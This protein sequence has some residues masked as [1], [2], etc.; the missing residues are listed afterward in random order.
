MQIGVF[1]KIYVMRAYSRRRNSVA[2]SAI[3]L[4]LIALWPSWLSYA[5]TY[6]FIALVWANHHYLMRYA[7][8][9]TPRLLW[10]IF[11]HFFDV[12]ASRATFR[13]AH[14]L[15]V[16][17][18]KAGIQYSRDSGDRTG[19]PRRT[20][21]PLSRGMTACYRAP[22]TRSDHDPRRFTFRRPRFYSLFRLRLQLIKL[23]AEGNDK[24]QRFSA[25]SS[26]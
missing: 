4:P 18:A 2:Y 10:F 7:T 23:A 8:E 21:Y 3:N 13:R 14:P 9:A 5:V 19:R 22:P 11:A 15:L 20:G 26:H 24:V 12:A 6:L 25:L 17:P 16:I 1:T